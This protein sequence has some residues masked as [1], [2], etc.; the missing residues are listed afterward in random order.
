MSNVM[1]LCLDFDGVIHSYD[2]GWQDGVI[3]GGVTPG[4]FEWAEKA[5]QHFNLVIYSS[6]SKTDEGRQA[7]EQWMA[8]R[9][10]E[11]AATR[12]T[13]LFPAHFSYAHEKPPAFLTIDDRALT[14][15]GDWGDFPVE[16]LKRFKPW[17][18]A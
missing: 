18:V 13:T 5:V 3:Y 14:F 4:F 1:I 7:M 6:R 2:R 10:H 8:D 16:G 12:N 11:W 17:N 15:G 9:Y